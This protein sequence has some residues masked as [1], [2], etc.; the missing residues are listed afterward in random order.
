MRPPWFVGLQKNLDP[1]TG[2]TGLT[3]QFDVGA[4]KMAGK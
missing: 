4:I 1:R 3:R 2:N